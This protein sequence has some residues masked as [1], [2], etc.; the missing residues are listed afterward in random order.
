MFATGSVEK[1]AHTDKKTS[2]H[3]RIIWSC[4]WTHDDVYFLTASRD[5]KVYVYRPSYLGLM[6]FN[7]VLSQRYIGFVSSQLAQ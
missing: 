1:V 3:S 7:S 2:V 6:I 4:C 5:K